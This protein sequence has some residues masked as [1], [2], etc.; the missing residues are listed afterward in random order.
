M[1][2]FPFN[3]LALLGLMLAVMHWGD[4]LPVPL[5]RVAQ[6]ALGLELMGALVVFTLAAAILRRPGFRGALLAVALVVCALALLAF[7]A[8]VIASELG[9]L[10][11]LPFV[12]LLLSPFVVALWRDDREAIRHLRTRALVVLGVMLAIVLETT[13]LTLQ[14]EFPMSP[15]TRA[16]LGYHPDDRQALYANVSMGLVFYGV[17]SA[18]ELLRLAWWRLTRNWQ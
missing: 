10:V 5:L 17:L 16:A 2:R 8:F 6:W 12:V 1:L 3:D 18:V 15:Q 14:T 7:F 4:A 9:M 11:L 13:A